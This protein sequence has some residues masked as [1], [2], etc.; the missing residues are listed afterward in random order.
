MP[1]QSQIFAKLHRGY[2]K[3]KSIYAIRVNVNKENEMRVIIKVYRS[4]EKCNAER[5][6]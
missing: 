5:S 6:L 2:S 1:P 3:K 4:A